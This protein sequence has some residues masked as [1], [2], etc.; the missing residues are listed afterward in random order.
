[1]TLHAS[2]A[3]W[4]P[5]AK[6]A[7]RALALKIVVGLVAA[8]LVAA[9]LAGYVLL[10]SLRLNPRQASPLTVVRYGYYY[11][12]RQEIRRIVLASSAAG[13]AGFGRIQGPGSCSTTSPSG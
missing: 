3:L 5:P 6:S 2:T 1:M 4:Q 7:R 9:Y 12:D 10:W 11:G 13:G 8:L